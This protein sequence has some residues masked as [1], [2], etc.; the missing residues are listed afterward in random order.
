MTEAQKA[1][2][3]ILE[4]IPRDR[5][6]THEAAQ[7]GEQG[8]RPSQ[9]VTDR[10]RRWISEHFGTMTYKEMAARLNIAVGSVRKHVYMLRLALKRGRGRPRKNKNG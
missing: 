7:P 6:H 4:S 3:R 5:V 1:H 10:R 9:A 8:A 2:L